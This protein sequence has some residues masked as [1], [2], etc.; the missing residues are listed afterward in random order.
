MQI[1]GD[2]VLVSRIEEEETD[3]FSTVEIQDN[4]IYK[5]KVEQV[6]WD[7]N[8]TASEFG[9]CKVGDIVYFAKYSPHTQDLEGMKVVRTEDLIAKE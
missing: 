3:G 8:S 9:V 7:N 6:G 1:I 2:R 4:F 5:G